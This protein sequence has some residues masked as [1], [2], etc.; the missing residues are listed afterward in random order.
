MEHGRE[1]DVVAVEMEVQISLVLSIEDDDGDALADARLLAL[2]RGEL[3]AGGHGTKAIRRRLY[4]I[5]SECIKCPDRQMEL[6]WVT[7]DVSYGVTDIETITIDKLVS[8][9]PGKEGSHS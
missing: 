3:A 9:G 4:D 8:V 7:Q 6:G 1:G 5:L 2:L